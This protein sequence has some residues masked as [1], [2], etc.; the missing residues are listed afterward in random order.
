[1]SYSELL[2]ST[3]S[4]VK[5]FYAGL[6]LFVSQQTLGSLR[7]HFIFPSPMDAFRLSQQGIIAPQALVL[8]TGERIGTRKSFTGERVGTNMRGSTQT[9]RERVDTN[10][11]EG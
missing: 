2:V 4:W 9:K 5:V 6:F 3:L 11:L 10:T 7:K 1:M 8:S